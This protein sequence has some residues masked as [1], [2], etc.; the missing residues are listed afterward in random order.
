[1]T[2]A[3]DGMVGGGYYDAHSTYQAKVAESGAVLFEQAVEAAALPADGRVIVADYGCGEGRNSIATIQ[4]VL[5]LLVPRTTGSPVVLHSDLPT[6]D[7]AGLAGNLAGDG[8]YL[9]TFPE[10]RA[11]FAPCGFFERVDDAGQRHD[12]N[13][14][15]RSALAVRPAARAR[16]VA[17]ALSFRRAAGRA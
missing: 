3:T 14:G 2:K 12:W 9:R 15:V 17:I 16:H 5:K 11:L 7:W 8:S 13:I 1:M 6:N 10:V 4:S